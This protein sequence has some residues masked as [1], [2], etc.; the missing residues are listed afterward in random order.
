VYF[1]VF[2]K[3]LT[4]SFLWQFSWQVNHLHM[5]A[6][7]QVNSASPSPM[8][9][10]NW[11]R[12]GYCY[13]QRRKYQA[14]CSSRPCWYTGTAGQRHCLLNSVGI[15]LILTTRSLGLPT[16]GSKCQKGISSHTTDL[17]VYAKSSSLII[18]PETSV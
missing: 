2:F 10:Q 8:S 16:A 11:P 6:A 15:Q 9:R 7:T 17:A 14:L 13:Q 4:Y 12:D 3:V 18:F 5:K 1:I